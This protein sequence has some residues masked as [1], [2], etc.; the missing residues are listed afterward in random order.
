MFVQVIKAKAKDVKAVK[1]A[2]ERWETD[3]KPGAI[4]YLGAT[5]GVADDGTFVAVARFESEEK[6]R[7]NSDRPEQ[8]QWWEET[9]KLFDGPVTFYN[10]PEVDTFLSGGSDDAGFVQVMIYKPKDVAAAKQMGKEFEQSA[11]EGRP[12]FMG[13]TTSYATDGT[14]ID[15]N[16]FTSEAEAREGERKEMPAEMQDVMERFQANAGEVE[17]IDLRDPW[18][19]SA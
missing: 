2:A 9:S 15:T 19:F 16:Y 6:A 10:C 12:D 8:G 13:A 5:E 7:A 18:L 14:V 1:A 17:Y 3:L 4:G 11:P